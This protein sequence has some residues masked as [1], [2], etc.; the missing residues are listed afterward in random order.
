MNLISIFFKKTCE[1]IL[2]VMIAETFLSKKKIVWHILL[3]ISN[4]LVKTWCRFATFCK[5]ASE[6]IEGIKDGSFI[7]SGGFGLQG[8][9]MNLINAIR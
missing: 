6:A 1:I 4:Q 3:M 8:L 7:L 2:L 5:T 9:P